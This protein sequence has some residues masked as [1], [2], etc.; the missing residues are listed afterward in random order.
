MLYDGNV[1][2][3]TSTAR[4][5]INPLKKMKFFL[6]ASPVP[7]YVAADHPQLFKWGQID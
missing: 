1:E 3:H 2:I 5:G 7:G 6:K 4:H